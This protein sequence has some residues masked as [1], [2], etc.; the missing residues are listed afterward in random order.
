MSYKIDKK[1]IEQAI[2]AFYKLIDGKKEGEPDTRYKSWEW[3][4]DAFR[5]GKQ[6]Y[7]I[8]EEEEIVD[9]LSLHLGFYLASW[10]MYRGS[11][12]LLQ[13]DYKAHKKVVEMILKADKSLWGFNPTS[14]NDIKNAR[15]ML[16][17]K[18]GLYMEIK[19]GYNN[20]KKSNDDDYNN[21][22]NSKEDYASDTLVTKILLGTLGCVPAFDRFLKKGIRW[23]K[24][25][26]Q[27]NDINEIN[28]T[29]ENRGEPGSTFVALSNF[30]KDNNETLKLNNDGAAEYPVMKCVDMFLWQ[31][32]YELDVLE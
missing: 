32:G 8:T 25:K 14:D 21:Y 30:A 17:G 15:E 3:C 13:R 26:Y 11:S 23:L 10:G 31:V 29:I 18:N 12:Y 16:F 24:E 28:A 7:D 27:D 19:N 2:N 4:Y 20:D 5:K 1:Y 22:E 6:E 9:Y